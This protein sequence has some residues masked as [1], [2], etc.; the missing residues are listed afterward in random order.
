MLAFIRETF[1][2]PVV[3]PL[4]LYFAERHNE[5]SRL[6]SI[7]M[8]SAWLTFMRNSCQSTASETLS[9]FTNEGLDNWKMKLRRLSATSLREILQAQILICNYLAE[10]KQ[11]IFICKET[12]TQEQIPHNKSITGVSH[13]EHLGIYTN[14]VQV[15]DSVIFIEGVRSMLIVRA[16]ERN[17]TQL[18]SPAV[19]GRVMETHSE[20][21]RWK[22]F[23]LHGNDL[24]EYHLS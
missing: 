4:L 21:N 17:T 22:E 19:I 9:L 2:K 14:D 18:I 15:G 5:F 11:G 12:T 23:E 3:S 10:L 20:V 24:Q 6:P 7:R 16:T 8:R 13:K 1:D